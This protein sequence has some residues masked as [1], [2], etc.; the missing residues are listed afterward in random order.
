MWGQSHFLNKMGQNPVPSAGDS[1]VVASE[2]SGGERGEMGALPPYFPKSTTASALSSLSSLRLCHSSNRS[3]DI[4][5][6][7]SE[8]ATPTD[9]FCVPPCTVSFCPEAFGNLLS[10]LPT[11]SPSSMKTKHHQ[12]WRPYLSLF[13]YTQPPLPMNITT[14]VPRRA[15]ISQSHSPGCSV[16]LPDRVEHVSFWCGEPTVL[17]VWPETRKSAVLLTLG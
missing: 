16:I 14:Y 2:W 13:P 12:G 11:L 1:L 3:S 15:W 7:G 6:S 9:P 17:L 4:W 8:E 5:G 10:S